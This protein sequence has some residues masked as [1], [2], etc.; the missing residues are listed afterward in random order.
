MRLLCLAVGLSLCL[1]ACHSANSGPS[2]PGRDSGAEARADA[3]AEPGER[4]DAPVDAGI[5][6]AKSFDAAW[7]SDLGSGDRAS[8]EAAEPDTP[9]QEALPR[10]DA[11]PL[12]AG[13]AQ[14]PSL[15]YYTGDQRS[16]DAIVNHRQWLTMVSADLFTVTSA[17]K[18]N[19]A[20][21]LGV[22]AYAASVGLDAYAC[23]SNYGASDFDP[24][25]AHAAMVTYK[26]QV[27]SQLVTLAGSR[28]TGINIDF[29]S[30]AYSTDI[31][32][33]R[34]AYASFVHD[35]ARALHEAGKK[36]IL[37]VP[38][39]SAD[40]P[41]DTWAYP[42]DL[43]ALGADA[44]FLQLMTYDENG[45]GWSGPGPVAGADWVRSCVAFAAGVAPPSKLLIGLPAYGYQWDLTASSG[46]NQQGAAVDWTG[47]VALLAAAGAQPHW[48][49][50]SLSP[51]LDY[52][53]SDGHEH[54]L[55][56]ENADSLEAKTA[57]VTQFGLG[58]LSMWAL[59]DEDPSFWE[60]AFRGL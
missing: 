9:S 49:T 23:V 57:L 12:D 7:T 39:K 43:A 58:G 41:D 22:A 18:V 29:E 45:P 8:R 44:D 15:G 50:A 59:G 6:D 46:G 16:Y 56:Y 3:P 34:A 1:L 35:L 14:V 10:A 47:F 31:H 11:S 30:L 55:W 2:Q 28:W 33:D 51:Y 5:A 13:S 48:D 19:G 32:T 21:D 60:A 40:R 25:L 53:T 4:A 26:T 52:T 20:D 17:G 27:V 36:L 38:G 54:E 37:S 42:Y 24:A